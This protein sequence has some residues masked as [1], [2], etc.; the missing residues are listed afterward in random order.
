MLTAN[1]NMYIIILD[2]T[3]KIRTH[4][5]LIGGYPQTCKKLGGRFTQTSVVA[6]LVYQ[7]THA[8]YHIKGN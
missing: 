4:F 2:V 3:K 8:L 7:S 1:I 6:M 5:D